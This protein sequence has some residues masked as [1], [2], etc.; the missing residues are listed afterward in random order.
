MTP[1]IANLNFAPMTDVLP[2]D[3]FFA[4]NGATIRYR[5]EGVGPPV[6]LV[7]GWTLDLEM[8]N[9]QV[10]SL[11]GEFRLVRFDRRGYGAS[12]GQPSIERDGDDLAGLCRHL[13]LRRFA[14]LG[15]SQGAR[16]VMRFAAA[17]P[18]RV[19]C[20]VLDGPPDLLGT[21]VAEVEV[22]KHYSLLART[23]GMAA[24]R[25]E[26]IND[27]LMRLQTHDPFALRALQGM[28]ERYPGKDLSALGVAAERESQPL[29]LESFGVPTLIVTGE[30]D[31]ADRIESAATLARCL[32][33]SERSTVP[34]A[35]HLP[36]LDNPMSYNAIV[37]AFLERHTP[38]PG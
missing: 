10:E 34:D 36:N 9:S 37:R 2:T 1:A 14:L 32:P 7:H 22:L 33:R 11:R 21:A 35:G 31:L 16:A 12:S 5:D 25:R 29:Q 19:S 8:W 13:A 27:P 30:H 38:M 17:A 26:W 4:C 28:I 18:N 23:K 15:M 24:F 20:V 3:R 6:L